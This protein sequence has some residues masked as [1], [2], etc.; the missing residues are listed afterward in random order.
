M[1]CRC[2]VVGSQV[3]NFSCHTSAAVLQLRWK[4]WSVT[5]LYVH[6]TRKQQYWNR[7]N[8][9]QLHT[10]N[11]TAFLF[12]AYK[13]YVSIYHLYKILHT[14]AASVQIFLISMPIINFQPACTLHLPLGSHSFCTAASTTGDTV[15]PQSV[16]QCTVIAQHMHIRSQ[17]VHVLILDVLHQHLVSVL[18]GWRLG[19]SYLQFLSQVVS[20]DKVFK[21]CM[22]L[23]DV[24]ISVLLQ[25]L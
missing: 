14:G 23:H 13:V 5:P 11:F 17:Q 18:G 21:L 15:L 9:R 8:P 6:F 20:C 1:S 16:P 2:Q 4:H 24:L 19:L 22:A 10:I 3:D 12:I 25:S 7:K